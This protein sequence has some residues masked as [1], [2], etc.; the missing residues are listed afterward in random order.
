LPSSENDFATESERVDGVADDFQT[1][2]VGDLAAAPG[3]QILAIAVKDHDRRV[4]ALKDVDPV[5][6]V[7]RDPT[8]QP[9]GL[10]W[11]QFAEIADQLVTVF[12]YTSLCHA[13]FPRNEVS[14]PLTA[15]E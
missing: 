10:P 7:G 13:A 3:S 15:A 4:L 12:A 11:R 2:R 14:S 5:L 6:L 1:V 9:E 8:D